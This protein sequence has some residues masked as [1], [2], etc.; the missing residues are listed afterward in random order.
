[1]FEKT[2]FKNHFGNFFVLFSNN[3]FTNRDAMVFSQNF[4]IST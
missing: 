1:M 2:T 4:E 3:K